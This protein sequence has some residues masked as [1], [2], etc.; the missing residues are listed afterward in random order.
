MD[1]IKINK[2]FAEKY[3]K[4]RKAEELQKCE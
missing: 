2:E 3:D 1:S 4:Y